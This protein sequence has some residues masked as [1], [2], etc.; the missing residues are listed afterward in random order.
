MLALLAVSASLWPYTLERLPDGGV[1][2]LAA[3]A[4]VLCAWRRLLPVA[5][6]L[7]GVLATVLAGEWQLRQD[8]PC[9]RDREQVT[10]TARISAPAVAR[11]GRIDLDVTP[12]AA[13]RADGLPSRVRLSWYEP[14]ARPRP[15]EV[16]RFPARLRCRS[17]LANPGGFDRELHLLR[18]GLGATGYVSGK[19]APRRLGGSAWQAPIEALRDTLGQSIAAAAGHTRSSGVLQGLAVGLR[20]AIPEELNEAFVATGTAHLIAIS[21][22]HVTAFAVAVL[23]L[24]RAGYRLFAGPGWAARWPGAQ[25]LLVTTVAGAYGLLAGA[26]VPTVRTM[27]MVALAL[28][29]RTARRAASIADILAVAALAMLAAGPLAVSS[30]GFWLSFVA[31]AAL[32]GLVRAPRGIRATVQSFIRAQSAVTVVLAPVLIGTFGAMSVVGPLVNAVAIPFFSVVLLPA[33]LGATA[34]TAVAPALAQPVWAALGEG[35]D[36]LWPWL[37]AA[38]DAPWAMWA[39]PA[40][41]PW[42]LALALAAA[43]AAVLL[44]ARA[45]RGLAVIPLVALLAR[46]PV[47]PPPG[48]FDLIVLDVGQGLAVVVRTARHTLVFDTGPRWQSGATAARVTLLPWFRQAG[49]DHADVV[50]VSHADSDHAGGFEAVARELSPRRVMGAAPVAEAMP[51]LAGQTWRWDGVRFEVVHPDRP[52]GYSRNDSSCALRVDAPGGR[53]L[54]LADPEWRAERAMSRRTLAAD[55]VLVAHHGSASSSSEAFIAAVGAR[56]ALVSAGFGNRWGLPRA[57]V[58]ERWQASGAEVHDTAASGALSV[59]VRPDTGV[60]EVAAYRAISRRWWRRS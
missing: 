23:A 42:L 33:V 48:G 52:D 36:R 41:P 49:L 43:L 20:A 14:Q 18:E 57:E 3:A 8:W 1:V 37:S 16:W 15:G 31:V 45:L 13:A 6:V 24:S 51:C 19:T 30:A 5:A 9:T 26:S 56:H 27:A 50:L 58:I 4:L 35:L 54:L 29:L 44:P 10:F 47:G 34:L 22:L 7:A 12:D 53:A 17:G 2:W 60:G 55:I 28:A 38:A 46:E 11:P 59:S 21:G 25:A 39:P 32:V 40:A